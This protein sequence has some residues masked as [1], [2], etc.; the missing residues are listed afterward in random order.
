MDWKII[1][2]SSLI[3]A[4]ITIILSV[5]YLPLLF[6]GPLVGGFLSSYLSQG[7]EDYAEM[8]KKDGAVVGALSGIIGGLIIGL[9]FILG[10]GP[11]NDVIGVLS[12]QIG[13]ITG[14][15]IISGYIVFQLSIV[16]SL[17]LGLVG[18]LIGVIVKNNPSGN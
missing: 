6:L 18:G 7:Y 12:S 11:I 14:S 3:N 2:L 1:G 10:V 8:G 13:T 16:I 9:I 17:I 5:I 4:A 15:I